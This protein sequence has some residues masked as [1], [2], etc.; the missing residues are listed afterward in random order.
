[1]EKYLARERRRYPRLKANF[2]ISYRIKHIPKDYDLSQTKNVSQGGLLLTTNKKFT[3]GTQLALTI[4]F[5]F[6][7]Q[8]IDVLGTVIDS[9][10]IVKNI[11]YETR[12]FFVNLNAAFFKELGVFI[13]KQLNQ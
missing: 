9:T 11:I 2:V 10:E 5:P 12:L 6:V 8:K 13:G 7:P 1:M 4:K 3:P